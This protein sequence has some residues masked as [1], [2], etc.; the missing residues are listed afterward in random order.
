MLSHQRNVRRL[1]CHSCHFDAFKLALTLMTSHVAHYTMHTFKAQRVGDTAETRMRWQHG[2][3]IG[4]FYCTRRCQEGW[5][6]SGGARCAAD[7]KWSFSQGV[8]EY[9]GS[10]ARINWHRIVTHQLGPMKCGRHATQHCETC[11]RLIFHVSV[12][13]R[14]TECV[15]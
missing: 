15:I 8:L 13:R 3:M 7:T 11:P 6:R 1:P 2:N 12:V 10:I 5:M 14:L 9:F 4:G